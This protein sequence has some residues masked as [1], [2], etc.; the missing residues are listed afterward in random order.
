MSS[1][2]KP[3]D[4][5]SSVLPDHYNSIDELP[6]WNWNQ[7]QTKS[8]FRYLLHDR[9]EEL[10]DDHT[11][12]LQGIWHA[13]QDDFFQR[14]G[15]NRRYM[16]ILRK[17]VE[18]QRMRNRIWLEGKLHLNNFV[19]LKEKELEKM[20]SDDKVLSYD[21]TIVLL[22]RSLRMQ[23]DDKVMPTSR[24]YAHLGRLKAA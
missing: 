18:I 19:H 2:K 4:E 16:D 23:I 6:I 13:M 14:F 11:T 1:S 12:Q 9:K 22:E 15:M 24:Y 5:C 17:R 3:K 10:T 20:L 8:D 21:D 7:I